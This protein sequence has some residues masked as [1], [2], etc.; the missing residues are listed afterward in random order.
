[1]KGAVCGIIHVVKNTLKGVPN[2]LM[3]NAIARFPA[4]F[5]RLPTMARV[6][7]Y[8]KSLFKCKL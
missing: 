7:L 5:E 1:M 4:L 8:F 3:A 2:L 6:I